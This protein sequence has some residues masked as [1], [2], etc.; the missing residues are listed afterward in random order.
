MTQRRADDRAR[1]P[2]VGIGAAAG[3]SGVHVETI[4]Y[5]ERIGLVPAPSRTASRYRRYASS[6]IGRLRFIRQARELGFTLDEIR[7]LLRIAEEKVHACDSARKIA[8][9]HLGAVRERIAVLKAM[10]RSLAGLVARC[11][12]GGRPYCP[13]IAALAEPSGRRNT[14]IRRRGAASGR[15]QRSR[16]P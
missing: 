6:D 10:E 5:Y 16:S 9:E 4:R 14:E 1:S 15:R 3:A 11:A 7:A 2:E 13:M 12:S 8:E